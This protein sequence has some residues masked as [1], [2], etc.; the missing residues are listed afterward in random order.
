MPKQEKN[1][2]ETLAQL[3][4]DEEALD[5]GTHPEIEPDIIRVPNWEDHRERID[6][7]GNLG[8]ARK[9][10]RLVQYKVTVDEEVVPAPQNGR[11]RHGPNDAITHADGYL[12]RILDKQLEERGPGKGWM[13]YREVKTY[14]QGEWRT[15]AR[16]V[17]D[18]A[19]QSLQELEQR[20]EQLEAHV[21][22]LRASR[23]NEMDSEDVGAEKELPEE[24]TRQ[25]VEEREDR[26]PSCGSQ[27]WDGQSCGFCRHG[28]E[29]YGV[30]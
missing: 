13:N 22:T 16:F 9:R 4:K 10:G 17:Y 7:L 19:T 20:V 5:E 18:P 1:S 8:P 24:T 25:F 29:G 30:A 6:R 14:I 23:Q 21:Q 2:T 12:P 28:K 11:N 26:C 15:I 27:E 3:L